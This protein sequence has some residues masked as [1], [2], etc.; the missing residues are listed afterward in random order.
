MN[1]LHSIKALSLLSGGLDSQLAVCVLKEQGLD[2][3]GIVFESPFFDAAEA[4]KASAQIGIELHILDFTTDILEL[5]NGPKHGFGSGLNPCI[6]CHARMLRRAGEFMDKEGFRFLSTGEVLNERP[7]SQNKR[8][9][10]IV[11]SESGYADL[12]VRPLSAGLLAETRPEKMGWVDRSRLLSLQGRSRKPQMELARKYGLREYPSPAGGCRLTEPNF[13][14]R[15]RDLKDHE[16]LGNLTAIRLL[17]VGRHFRLSD[18]IKLVIGRNQA[19][20][21]A[22]ETHA[23]PDDLVLKIENFAGPTGLMSGKASEDQIRWG[24]ALCARYGDC[25]QHTPVTVLVQSARETRRVEV[26]PASPDEANRQMI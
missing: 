18:H 8:S 16:G 20:N 9:L 4:R 3:H 1:E 13:A 5:L 11:A 14:K 24:G 15:L 17:R 2:V 7:M 26:I 23:T 19:D 10:Q 22:L 25:P 6:D 21:A 12:I